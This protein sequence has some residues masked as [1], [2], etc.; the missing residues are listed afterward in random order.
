MTDLDQTISTPLLFAGVFQGG[1]YQNGYFVQLTDGAYDWVPSK[2]FDD[3]MTVY[4]GVTVVTTE[5]FTNAPWDLK[6]KLAALSTAVPITEFAPYCNYCRIY[7]H[8][9]MFKL[10]CNHYA[11]PVCFGKIQHFYA[12]NR[13]VPVSWCCGIPIKPF[14]IYDSE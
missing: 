8:A 2:C 13:R 12:V 4:D 7:H 9:A 5:R 10:P 6:L 3:F 1:I 14:E 11:H